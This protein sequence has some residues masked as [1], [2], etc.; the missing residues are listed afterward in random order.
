[1]KK[2]SLLVLTGTVLTKTVLAE[3][4]CKAIDPRVTD[5]WCVLDCEC[6]IC[7]GCNQDYCAGFC[8]YVDDD[9]TTVDPNAPT[10]STAK[11]TY[12]P[13]DSPMPTQPFDPETNL[14]GSNFKRN[15]IYLDYKIDWSHLENDIMASIDACF[16]V[17]VLSFYIGTG[18]AP[19]DALITWSGMSKADRQSILDYSHERG[20]V[21]M[22]SL[23]GATDHI[24]P[25]VKAGTGAEY[26]KAACQ[27]CIDYDLDGVDFDIELDPGNNG[28]FMDGSMQQFIIDGTQACRQI[29]GNDLLI[30]HAPQAPYL[31]D[32]AGSSLGYVEVFNQ[33][34][35]LID[36][37]SIQFYNQGAQY[38]ST[39]ENLFIKADGWTSQSAVKEMWDNGVPLNKIVVGKPVG[40][41]GY[42]SNGYVDPSLLN[43]WGCQFQCETGWNGGYMNWMYSKGSQDYVNFG[44]AIAQHCPPCAETTTTE[45][46]EPTLSPQPTTQPARLCNSEFQR[47]VIYLDYK[48][49]WS[50]LDSDIYSCV[51]NCFN[52]IVLG[53][54]LGVT[55]S[56]ADALITW[57][58][59]SH[60]D[61]QTILNNVHGKGG[62][63]M[64]SLGG[65]TDH[66][67][68]YVK[69][70]R[71]AEY[72]AQ[73]C[74]FAVDND[75][76][77]VDFDIE[78][79]PGN[80]GPFQ[81]G[82]MQQF[83]I[84][85]TQ[86]CREVFAA[87]GRSDNLISHAPQGPYFGD[88]A[89][90]TKGYTE[91]L[92][93]H[94]DLIDFVNVQYYNQGSQYYVSYQD[95][96]IASTGFCS[97]SAVMEMVNNGVDM[98]KIVVGKPVGPAGYA[99]NG[100][101]D[102]K[103]LNAWGCQAK[104]DFGWEGGFMNWMFSH[105]QS[106]YVYFGNSIATAC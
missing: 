53:F 97:N 66:I 9:A 51:D 6:D 20:V 24:E 8:D 57:S 70:G 2:L 95:L 64:M 105:G 61:R 11:P 60:S 91:V 103:E 38:Y 74:Q 45:A 84:D 19:A 58:S 50:H 14:C 98:N 27:F 73:A 80:N 21:I 44:T 26:S 5:E 99:S 75:L 40:P 25:L 48:I 86:K 68:D 1:M 88:W 82:T 15:V 54:Y 43:D 81:D 85:G 10:S 83:I 93:N 18:P 4:E 55:N 41:A 49:D 65:A 42:A 56:A 87:N 33:M 37:V 77:G 96:F 72:A 71:G 106:D 28:P 94:P 16:N 36:F 39:Y 76:D 92:V 69:T 100:Y 32:W 79:S 35:G 78:L 59:Y 67:E 47:N 89:G 3:P 62:K 31:G 101:V 17:I 63:I 46:P 7:P 23:G 30:S 102:P 104:R 90:P 12:A 13:T 52:V 29:I 34:P 22:M